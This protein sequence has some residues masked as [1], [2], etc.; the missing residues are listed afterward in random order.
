[1]ENKDSENKLG[2][3][4]IQTDQFLEAAKATQ[5]GGERANPRYNEMDGNK[6]WSIKRNMTALAMKEIDDETMQELFKGKHTIAYRIALRNLHKAMMGDAKHTEIA[7]DRLDGKVES[8]I[9][10]REYKDILDKDDDYLKQM[11]LDGA[12][13]IKKGQ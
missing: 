9:S 13:E 8:P 12:E 5:F 7:L 1:M 4:G 2:G 6:P 3:V 11:I 10:I